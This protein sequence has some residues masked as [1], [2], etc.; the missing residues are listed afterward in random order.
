[1]EQADESFC[2]YMAKGRSLAAIKTHR[3]AVTQAVEDVRAFVMLCGAERALGGPRISG[4][5]FAGPLP[6]GWIRNASAPHMA[7]PDTDTTRGISFARKMATLRIPDN[8]EFASL[9]GAEALPST[10]DPASPLIT[11]NWPS[12]EQSRNGW[13]IKCP[14]D[15]D[16]KHAVPPDAVELSRSEYERE[17]LAPSFNLLAFDS[18]TAEEH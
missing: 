9:I 17:L 5:H 18:D 3:K 10:L 8:A 11:V 7:F 12:Y 13:I 14:V 16:G 2:Y 1:M 4:L 15:R 6:R